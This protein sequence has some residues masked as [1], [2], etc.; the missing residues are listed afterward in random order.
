MDLII[1][2][3]YDPKLDVKKTQE[4]IRLYSGDLPR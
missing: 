4:A 2:K 3:D 1:P